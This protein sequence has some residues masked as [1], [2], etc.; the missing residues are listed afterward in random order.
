MPTTRRALL[1]ERLPW[2][3]STRSAL[4]A[5]VTAVSLLKW[6]ATG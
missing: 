3:R 2:A 5:I 4:S 1:W 6:V